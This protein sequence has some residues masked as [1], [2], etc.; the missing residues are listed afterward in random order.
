MLVGSFNHGIQDPILRM[1]GP[2]A[3]QDGKSKLGQ[4]ASR[5]LSDAQFTFLL[6]MARQGCT[7]NGS[8]RCLGFALRV[9]NHISVPQEEKMTSDDERPRAQTEH[10]N[11]CMNEREVRTEEQVKDRP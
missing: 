6:A 2:F 11:T 4:I 8:F 1:N 9:H 10:A 7:S 5:H 3:L